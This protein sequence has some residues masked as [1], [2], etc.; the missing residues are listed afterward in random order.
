MPLLI[1]TNQAVGRL[2]ESRAGKFCATGWGENTTVRE[3]FEEGGKCLNASTLVV[4]GRE[5]GREAPRLYAIAG[6]MT[7]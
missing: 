2:N 4:E 5:T 1:D 7:V 3:D 6:R